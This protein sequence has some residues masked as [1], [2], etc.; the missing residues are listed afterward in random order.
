MESVLGTI[1]QPR[2]IFEIGKPVIV[3]WTY[4]NMTV[5]FEKDRVLRTVVHANALSETDIAVQQ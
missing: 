5:Y 3:R 2:A 1:G 4:A